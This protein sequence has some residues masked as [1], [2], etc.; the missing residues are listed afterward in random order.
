M[1][2]ETLPLLAICI[3]ISGQG[4]F[5]IENEALVMQAE[6]EVDT[7]STWYLAPRS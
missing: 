4:K 5:S 1:Q 3:V 2:L 7:F 6:Q